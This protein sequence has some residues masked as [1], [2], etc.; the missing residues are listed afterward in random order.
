MHIS[1]ADIRL[2]PQAYARL[3]A[4][5]IG[6]IEC[7]NGN[8]ILHGMLRDHP[9]LA[10]KGTSFDWVG[11]ESN[12]GGAEEGPIDFKWSIT[13]KRKAINAREIFGNRYLHDQRIRD[14]DRIYLK[15][16]ADIREGALVEVLG[17]GAVELNDPRRGNDVLPGIVYA[18][19]LTNVDAEK[20]DTNTSE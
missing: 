8:T 19:R 1:I 16:L 3:Q 18:E 5:N 14:I 2:D 4:T 20:E 17:F 7:V 15:A 13:D 6:L 9:G 10:L 11:G 12:A